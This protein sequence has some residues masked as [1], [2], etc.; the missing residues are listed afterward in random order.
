MLIGLPVTTWQQV[1]LGLTN[2]RAEPT[3][4]VVPKATNIWP[5]SREQNHHTTGQPE[6]KQSTRSEVPSDELHPKLFPDAYPPYKQS[7]KM[8][9]PFIF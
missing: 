8:L 5:R 6:I 2:I 1:V 7:T 9:I 3:S 4:E